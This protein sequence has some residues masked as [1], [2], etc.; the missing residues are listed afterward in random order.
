MKSRSVEM[1][2]YYLCEGEE[3]KTLDLA[4]L[5]SYFAAHT[6][7]DGLPMGPAPEFLRACLEDTGRW[8]GTHGYARRYLILDCDRFSVP[9]EWPEKI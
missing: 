2:V 7:D 6:H 3:T 8:E 1:R 9:L 5:Q 4:E